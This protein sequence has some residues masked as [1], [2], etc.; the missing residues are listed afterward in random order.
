MNFAGNRVVLVRPAMT[1]IRIGSFEDLKKTEV[2]KMVIGNPKT[3][4]AGRYAEEVLRYL[5][6]WDVL[7]NNLFLLNML[8]RRWTTSHVMR[9]M[10]AWS[11]RRM[12]WARSNEG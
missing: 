6:L 9:W 5:T 7:K 1:H 2:K 11:I 4:P 10:Q 8:G 12:P 3:V